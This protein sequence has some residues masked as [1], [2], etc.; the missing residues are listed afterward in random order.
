[1]ADVGKYTFGYCTTR[2]ISKYTSGMVTGIDQF[3]Y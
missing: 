2:L 1:M 3:I